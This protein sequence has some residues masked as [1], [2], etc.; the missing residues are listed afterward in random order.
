M[1]RNPASGGL[2]FAETRTFRPGLRLQ[3]EALL[4]AAALA[5]A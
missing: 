3:I 1:T 2:I 4:T 5:A